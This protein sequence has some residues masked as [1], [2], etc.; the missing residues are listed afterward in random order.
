MQIIFSAARRGSLKTEQPALTFGEARARSLHLPPSFPMLSA[1]CSRVWPAKFAPARC[2]APQIGSALG[3]EWKA[4]DEEAKA[5]YIA[6]AAAEK[7][8][9]PLAAPREK[10]AKKVQDRCAAAS[11]CACACDRTHAAAHARL[12]ASP[13]SGAR[14]HPRDRRGG[15]RR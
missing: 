14:P 3:A 7:A 5:P 6:Q 4:L 2:A 12:A 9:A 1:I 11:V 10:K 13:A 8:A 15:G